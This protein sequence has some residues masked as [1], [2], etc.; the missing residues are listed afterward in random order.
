MRD[1]VLYVP[2]GG[3]RATACI[4][5]GSAIVGKPRAGSEDIEICVD[6]ANFGPAGMR[7]LAERA[8]YAAV[9]LLGCCPSAAGRVVPREALLVVGTFDLHGGRIRL[10]GPDS[11]AAVAA[12]LG[13]DPRCWHRGREDGRQGAT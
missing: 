13:I 10:T 2:A 7:T 12:W 8:R 11:K 5:R 6:E 9:Q 4:A 3:H 1:I